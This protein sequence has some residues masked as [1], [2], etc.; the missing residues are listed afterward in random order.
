MHRVLW[1]SRVAGRYEQGLDPVALAAS[2]LGAYARPATLTALRRASSGS[3]ALALL[4]TCTSTRGL[5][6]PEYSRTVAAR[7]LFKG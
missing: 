5:S 1:A 4:L 7:A 3:R 6:A 2:C